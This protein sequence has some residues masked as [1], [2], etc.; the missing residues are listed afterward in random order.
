[1]SGALNPRWYVVHTQPRGETRAAMHLAQQ[2]F[3]VYLPRYMKRRRH[4]RRVEMV[5]APLFPR[6]LF[7]ALDTGLQRWRAVQSTMGVSY[8]VCNGDEPTA[9]SPEIIQQIKARENEHGL[10]CLDVQPRFTQG[11]KVR[12]LDGALAACLG[13]F[14]E[15]AD[16]NRVSILL[17]LLGR[18]VRVLLNS[19]QLEAA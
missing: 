16:R 15:N 11:D 9:L 13:L 5:A 4:A 7:V 17:D 19:E 10:I 2:G 6:Y 1:M 18:K 12:V 3:D 8:L 14:E